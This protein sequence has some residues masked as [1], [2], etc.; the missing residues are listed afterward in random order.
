M[1]L[2]FT[3][4]SYGS[5]IWAQSSN[6]NVKRILRLQNKAFCI[7]NL[8]SYR[9]HANPLFNNLNVLKFADHVEL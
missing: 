8:A 5:I 9:D 4:L 3:L 1:S 2:F 6:N 7:I